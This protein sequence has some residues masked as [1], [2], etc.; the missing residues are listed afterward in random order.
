MHAQSLWIYE[1]LL[2]KAVDS[3]S[4]GKSITAGICKKYLLGYLVSPTGTISVPSVWGKDCGQILAVAFLRVEGQRKMGF[5]LA[6]VSFPYSI[7]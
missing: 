5:Q 6:C 1:E 7:P 2:W 3:H 4:S